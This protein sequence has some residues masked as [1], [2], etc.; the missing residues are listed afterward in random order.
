MIKTLF[1]LNIAQSPVMNHLSERKMI[2]TKSP[3]GMVKLLNVR[4]STEVRVQR[5]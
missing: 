3:M 5:R 1:F 2:Q 4:A